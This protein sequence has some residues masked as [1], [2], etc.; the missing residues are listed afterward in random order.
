MTPAIMIE[1]GGAAV[2]VRCD[3]RVFLAGIGDRYANFLTATP[4]VEP[5]EMN[6]AVGPDGIPAVGSVRVTCTEGRWLFERADFRAEWSPGAGR[7]WI[8]QSEPSLHSFDSV[9][10]ILHSLLVVSRGGF[11]LH[12]ASAIRHGSA[13]LFSGVSGAGKTTISRLAPPDAILL[14]DEI[15]YIVPMEGGGYR[16]FGTPFAGD[17]GTPGDN[18]SAPLKAAYLLA[19]GTDNRSDP[20]LYREAAAGLLRNTLFFATEPG[21]VRLVFDTACRFAASVPV[22]RLT[23]APTPRIWEMIV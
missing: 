3:D 6:L 2:L 18:V 19:Q 8:R 15:S 13:F 4:S 22:R 17:L 9:L 14:T 21:L 20:V 16:A 5:V 10:R 1:I 11:L 7:A 23:F 12:A